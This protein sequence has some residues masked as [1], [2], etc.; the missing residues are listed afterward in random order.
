MSSATYWSKSV[1]LNRPMP[2]PIDI[3]T[4]TRCPARRRP[5]GS[6]TAL[7]IVA[8][9]V[10]TLLDAACRKSAPP[11]LETT[12]RIAERMEPF[13]GRS[14]SDGCALDEERRPALGCARW[15]VLVEVTVPPGSVPNLNR[16]VAVA[17]SP[18]SH[19]PQLHKLTVRK[20]NDPAVDLPPVVIS[21]KMPFRMV[22]LAAMAGTRAEPGMRLSLQARAAARAHGDPPLDIARG[23]VLAFG[24][25]LDP[26][27]PR[28]GL[29]GVT[30]RISAETS[31]GER[32]LF[33]STLAADDEGSSRWQDHRVALDAVAGPATRL[34][35]T[36]QFRLRDGADDWMVAALPLW[37]ADLVPSAEPAQ[38]SCSSRSTPTCRSRGRLRNN[39]R[40]RR[41]STSCG[42]RRHRR[43][44]SPCAVDD[45]CAHEHA[46]GSLSAS[47]GLRMRG[48]RLHSDVPTLAKLLADR[49]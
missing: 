1:Q 13:V 16:P 9:V 5:A 15:K 20:A 45:G 48:T 26:D 6:V 7:R 2:V 11:S 25:G 22:D 12:T 29:A 17:T 39:L 28:D 19:R 35:F 42:R 18:G 47:N 31:G 41:T 34:V 30:F 33:E 21:A 37:G 10:A 23:S 24:I 27:V 36:T 32:V 8:V 4:S 44:C 43:Q 3:G 38:T 49:G 40:R 46:H 14:V